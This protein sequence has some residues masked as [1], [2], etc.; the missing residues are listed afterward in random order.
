MIRIIQ[1]RPVDRKERL[2]QA[3][4]GDRNKKGAYQMWVRST[5]TTQL[6]MPYFSQVLKFMA[7]LWRSKIHMLKWSTCK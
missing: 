4:S 5:R 7:N 6:T 3:A 2:E 1:V